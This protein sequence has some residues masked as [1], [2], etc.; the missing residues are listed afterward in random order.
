M[1]ILVPR[2]SGGYTTKSGTSISAGMMA[3]ASALLLEW[4]VVEGNYPTMNTGEATTYFIRGADRKDTLAYP[5][6]QWGYGTLN[7]YQ[8]FERI[9]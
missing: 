9:L 1:N 4:A 2:S 7:M 6:R 5:N 3:G 8:V